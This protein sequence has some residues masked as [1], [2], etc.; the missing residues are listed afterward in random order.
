MKNLK[1]LL[2]LLVATGLTI[3]SGYVDAYMRKGSEEVENVFVPAQVDC[4][5][6]EDVVDNKKTS[7]TA[8][9]TSNVN[10][11]I[12]MRSVSYWLDENGDITY[13]PSPTN[14]IDY[15]DIDTDNWIVD[16]ANNTFYYKYPVG[17][18]E[19]AKETKNLLKTG[20]SIV[21]KTEGGRKQVIEFFAEAIQA[22][23]ADAA[24][25]AWNVTINADGKIAGFKS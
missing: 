12:R 8:I 21:L 4:L 9:N 22:D 6:D 13:Y 10:A 7:V 1:W 17:T 19:T 15:T 2:L 14:Y 25:A 5:V 18:A 20:E 3:A 24:I 23:P 11:Y 16:T